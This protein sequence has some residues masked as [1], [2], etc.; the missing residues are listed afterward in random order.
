MHRRPEVLVYR[1]CAKR[2]SMDDVA[3]GVQG[4]I[5]LMPPLRWEMTLELR[6]HGPYIGQGSL[7]QFGMV[8]VKCGLAAI[9]MLPRSVE[10]ADD[11]RASISRRWSCGQRP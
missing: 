1:H 8:Q 3:S 2:C 5:H 9:G 7:K 11:A 6:V 10:I 4:R